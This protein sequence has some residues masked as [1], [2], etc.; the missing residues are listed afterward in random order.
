MSCA[1]VSH[2]PRGGP[3]LG[4][5]AAALHLWRQPAARG[6]EGDLHVHPT[7][8]FTLFT[9]YCIIGIGKCEVSVIFESYSTAHFS[10]HGL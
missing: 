7:G 8:W 2:L 6:Q 3:V 10:T 1:G 4:P 5:G 9:L